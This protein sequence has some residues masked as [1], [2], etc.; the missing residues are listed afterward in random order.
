MNY[1]LKH[2]VQSATFKVSVYAGII[3]VIIG[4]IAFT[5]S[6]NLWDVWGGPLQGYKEYLFPGNL[7]L[8]YIWHPL[9]TEEVSC[10]PKLGY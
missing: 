5:L 9:F 2:I 1:R 7:T 3:A 6:W 4:L 10:W 8:I